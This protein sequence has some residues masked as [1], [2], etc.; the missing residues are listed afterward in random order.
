MPHPEFRLSDEEID[1]IVDKVC[2]KLETRIYHNVGRGVLGFVWRGI[3]LLIIAVAGFGAGQ[4]FL[5]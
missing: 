2:D 4:H 1:K 3:I 5:K